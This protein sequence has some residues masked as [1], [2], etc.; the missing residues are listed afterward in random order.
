M[1][2]AGDCERNPGAMFITLRLTNNPDLNCDVRINF[3]RGQAMAESCIFALTL[4][5]RLLREGFTAWIKGFFA[6]SIGLLT[7]EKDP[8]EF[9]LEKSLWARLLRRQCSRLLAIGLV[10]NKQKHGSASI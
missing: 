2:L 9:E 6:I 1:E 10:G 8:D 5:N 7:T 3:R 4:T